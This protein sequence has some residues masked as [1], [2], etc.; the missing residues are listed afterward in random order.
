M[1]CPPATRSIR[2]AAYASPA[3]AAPGPRPRRRALVGPSRRSRPALEGVV[4]RSRQQTDIAPVDEA[5]DEADQEAAEGEPVEAREEL[6]QQLGGM[7]LRRHDE[8]IEDAENEG[9]C[10]REGERQGQGFDVQHGGPPFKVATV[11][12]PAGNEAG[13]PA[14]ARRTS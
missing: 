3:G 11:K 14:F 6:L 5:L 9:D 7:V 8:P 4:E 13:R 1:A 2:G 10:R 12:G